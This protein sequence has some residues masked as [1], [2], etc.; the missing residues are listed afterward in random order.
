M[1]F[2]NFRNTYQQ[3]TSVTGAMSSYGWTCVSGKEFLA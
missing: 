1:E 3:V 2:N